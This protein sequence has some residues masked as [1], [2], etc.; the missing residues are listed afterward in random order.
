[1][2]TVLVLLVG[3][4]IAASELVGLLIMIFTDLFTLY[5]LVSSVVGYVELR[6]NTLFIRFG[7]FITRE[8]PYAKIRSVKKE[9]RVYSESM[10]A[11]KNSLDHVDIRYN[12]FDVVSVSVK[13]NDDLIAEIEAR[14]NEKPKSGE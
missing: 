11:L 4:V 14:K 5:F 2:P 7:F 9:R 1:V 6:E 3:T 12:S 8:I 13:G 10:L